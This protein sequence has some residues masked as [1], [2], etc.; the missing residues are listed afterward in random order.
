MPKNDVPHS[1]AST[2]PSSAPTK[3][4]REGRYNRMCVDDLQRLVKV[5]GIRLRD[6]LIN[7]LAKQDRYHADHPFPFLRLPAELRNQVYSYLLVP[8]RMT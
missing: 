4:S 8:S 3:T 6:V 5:R 1:N 2:K 7:V